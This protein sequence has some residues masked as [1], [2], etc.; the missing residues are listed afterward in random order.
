[1][2]EREIRLHRVHFVWSVVLP[3]LDL[4]LLVLPLTSLAISIVLPVFSSVLTEATL[5]GSLLTAPPGTSSVPA[6]SNSWTL[7]APPFTPPPTLRSVLPRP[8]DL[9]PA[10]SRL[11]ALELA[12]VLSQLPAP[13]VLS[14]L[15][16]SKADL[17]RML[18][19]PDPLSSSP[20]TSTSP[21]P[22]VSALTVM[23]TSVSLLTAPPG[24][25]SVPARSNSWT[26]PAPPFTPPPT[27]RSVLPLP[28][29]LFPA[30]SRLMV[31][32]LAMVLSQLPAPFVLSDLPHSKADLVR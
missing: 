15:P 27:L 13:F 29:D 26:L 17:V 30:P 14:D 24:T 31:L 2:E 6:R 8:E 9:F 1:M 21:P 16:H 3:D 12:M 32:E 4:P 25:S 23:T 18:L 22:S 19:P 28:E 5:F 11:M 10:P 7:P 20:A